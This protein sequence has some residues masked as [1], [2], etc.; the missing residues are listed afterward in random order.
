MTTD[1]ATQPELLV[2]LSTMS[3]ADQWDEWSKLLCE[4]WEDK[5]EVVHAIHAVRQQQQRPALMITGADSKQDP[6]M[7]TPVD[8]KQEK[9]IET[10][11][12]QLPNSVAEQRDNC[13]FDDQTTCHMNQK[14]PRS[15]LTPMKPAV[16]ETQKRKSSQSLVSVIGDSTAAPKRQKMDEE[17]LRAGPARRSSLSVVVAAMTATPTKGDS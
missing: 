9:T 4:T 12:D 16:F 11:V 13:H 10:V 1:G 15:S 5:A 8:S 7:I 3:T 17:K 14:P 2:M 6:S